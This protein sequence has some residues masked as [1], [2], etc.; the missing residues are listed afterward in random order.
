MSARL[1]KKLTSQDIADLED[2]VAKY[3]VAA[4]MKPGDRWP[5][6]VTLDHMDCKLCRR[7]EGTPQECDPQCPVK[8]CT[9]SEACGRTPYYAPEKEECF[10]EKDDPL[11]KLPILWGSTEGPLCGPEYI[12]AL[13]KRCTE[14]ADFLQSLID[15]GT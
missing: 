1:Y 5:E 4:A 12:Q 10:E 7:Y 11:L 15:N 9:G 3:R 14:E 2:A 13:Q 8:F 6:E